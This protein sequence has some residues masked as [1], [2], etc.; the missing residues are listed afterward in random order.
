MTSTTR[1]ILIGL[2]LRVATGLF[3]GEKAEL[4]DFVKEGYLRLLQMTV[5]LISDP[6]VTFVRFVVRIVVGARP[7]LRGE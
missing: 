1:N 6:F 7:V 3:F 4:L 2:A 5:L